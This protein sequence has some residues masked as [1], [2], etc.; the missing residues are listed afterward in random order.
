MTELC[1]IAT[2]RKLD[3]VSL[4]AQLNNPQ[5]KRKPV[6]VEFRKGNV[7]VRSEHWRFIRYADGSEELY[8]HR[9]D[10]KEWVNLQGVAEHQPVK[11]RLAK[12][13]PVF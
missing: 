2:N 8:D 9:Q 7:A 1:G 6:L 12:R 11:K 5:A 13:L 4:V 3:G 10:P